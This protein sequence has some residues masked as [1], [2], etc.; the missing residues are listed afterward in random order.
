VRRDR[1]VAGLV[2]T[3]ALA[4]V[5]VPGAVGSFAPSEIQ[6]AEAERFRPVTLDAAVAGAVSYDDDPAL[7]SAS[8]IGEDA[9]LPEPAAAS[10]VPTRPEIDQPEAEPGSIVVHPWRL[11][12][13]VSWYGPGF[14]GK[15][16]ACG[17]AYTETIVGVAHRSLPCGTKVSFRHP[18]TGKVVTTTVIDRGPYV[19]GRQ[20]DLSAGLCRALGHCYTGPLYWRRG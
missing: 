9:V 16:T 19:E 15:R 4:L 1:W 10:A 20:W 8:A 13:D 11:D 12:R 5:A 2:L 18:E 17:Q 14:Y 7:R 6:A 3:T